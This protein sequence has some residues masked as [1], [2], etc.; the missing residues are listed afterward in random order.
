MIVRRLRELIELGIRV[1][2]LFV[3]GVFAFALLMLR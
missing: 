2:E 3:F 1:F